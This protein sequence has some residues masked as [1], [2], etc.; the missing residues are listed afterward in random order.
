MDDGR[1]LP[2]EDV[3]PNPDFV[4]TVTRDFVRSCQTPILV[5]PDDVPAHPYAVAMEF[6]ASRAECRGEHL[7]VEGVPRIRLP[8]RCATCTASCGRMHR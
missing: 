3:P 6:R 7:S 5:L 2:E 8:R 4:F 1:R